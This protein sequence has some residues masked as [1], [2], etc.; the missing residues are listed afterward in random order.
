MADT[1]T[2]VTQGKDIA[3]TLARSFEQALQQQ[4][5]LW[6]Q[7]NRFARD[8]SYRIGS[9]QLEHANQALENMHKSQGMTGM[10]QAHQDWLR[11]LVQ[12]YA[13]Q[14]IRYSEMLRDLSSNTFATALDAGRRGMAM[15]QEAMRAAVDQAEETA[16]TMHRS[17]QAMAEAAGEGASVMAGQMAPQ[18]GAE[19]YG[20]GHVQH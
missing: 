4:R 15:G 10:V 8:E 11:K 18:S 9:R 2:D 20:N 6:E 13:D 12:D 17:G 1:D 7:V 14:S 5:S 16:E 3:G 19:P